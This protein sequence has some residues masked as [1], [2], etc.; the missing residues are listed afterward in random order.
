VNP[1]PARP[2]QTTHAHIFR[3][4]AEHFV[5]FAIP[6]APAHSRTGRQNRIDFSR[7]WIITARPGETFAR[8]QL[9]ADETI[10]PTY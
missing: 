10:A 1:K 6:I 3:F 2:G 7:L 4:H 9:V 8:P 5:E